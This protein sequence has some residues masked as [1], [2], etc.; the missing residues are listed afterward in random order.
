MF[1][2]IQIIII[3]KLNFILLYMKQINIIGQED[4]IYKNFMN[5]INIF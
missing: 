1:N 2:N 5:N 4:S 3:C